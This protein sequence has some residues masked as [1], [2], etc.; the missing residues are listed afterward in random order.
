MRPIFFLCFAVLCGCLHAAIGESQSVAP[1]DA[2]AV[3]RA[4]EGSWSIK[5]D[6]LDTAHSKASH[7]ETSLRNDCWR[8]GGFYACNQYVNGESK[9]LIVFTYDAEKGRYTTYPIPAGGGP[10]GS[11]AL[12]IKGNVWTFPWEQ[13]EDGKTTHYRVVNVF[14]SPTKISYRREFST[15]AVSWTVM[16]TGNE[17]KL[18]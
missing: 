18:K 7:E 11:G 15:D 2:L 13:T 5:I 12:E 4:Y 17:V 16:A 14:E 1:N 3:I 9:A 6:N 10:A 8:S